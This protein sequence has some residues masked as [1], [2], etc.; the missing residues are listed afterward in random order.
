MPLAQFIR[1][2]GFF[3]I[4]HRGASGDAPENTL[5]AIQKAI[6]EGALMIEMDVQTTLDSQLIV[7][8]DNVLGRTTNGH[9]HVNKTTLEEIRSLD[10]GSWFDIRYANERIPLIDEALTLIQGKTYLNLEIKPL[11]N[12]AD[13]VKEMQELVSAIVERN[14]AAYTVFAS[15]DHRALRAVKEINANL[16]TAA[17]NVPGDTRLPSEVVSA[18]SADAYG[19]SVHELTRKK[20]DDCENNRI[21]WGVYTVNTMSA[22]KLALDHGVNCVVSNYPARILDMMN[23]PRE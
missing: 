1:S 21:P 2:S 15:F 10:A 16:H 7:F 6:D 3:V 12:H 23:Q 19:C 5:S 8:H 18:C 13:A 4:A 9:G 14:M 11:S 20:A 22:L 17:L